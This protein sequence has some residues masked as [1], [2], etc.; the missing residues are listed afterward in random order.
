MRT[1]LRIL[2]AGLGVLGAGVT[3]T[4]APVSAAGADT[5]SSDRATVREYPGRLVLANA[6]AGDR[7]EVTGYCG[8][9]V[10]V[11]ITARHPMATPTGWVQRGHLT[12]ASREGGLDG[13]PQRCGDDADRWRDWVGAINA[14]FH[15][16][17]KVDGG[18]RR[19]VF[20][21]RVNLAATPDCVPSLNYTREASGPDRVDPT[22]RV[23]G[24]DL[25]NVGFRYVTT[26]GSVALVSS[27]RLGASYGVWA[28]VPSACVQPHNRAT[29]YFDEPVVQLTNIAGLKTGVGYP[30]SVIRSRG[31]SAAVHSPSH[32]AFGYW[33]DPVR[34]PGCPV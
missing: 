12:K 9:W 2:L 34:R 5:I 30:D 22:Q 1:S 17:R 19:I 6:T 18:W 31:C 24:L 8:S 16:L 11:R 15:S 23:S 29:V 10:R 21:T 13:V 4:A 25:G 32:P 33:P 27:P 7:A 3:L 28:F 26:D 20:G 14:P